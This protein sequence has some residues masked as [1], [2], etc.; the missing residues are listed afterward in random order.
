MISSTSSSTNG[1][2]LSALIALIMSVITKPVMSYLE[3][4]SRPITDPRTST[5]ETSATRVTAVVRRWVSRRPLPH[6]PQ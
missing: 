1:E 6:L 4:S 2:L 5:R 3:Y